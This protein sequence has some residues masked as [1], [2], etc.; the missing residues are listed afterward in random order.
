[1]LSMRHRYA[2]SS[3]NQDAYKVPNSFW[4]IGRLDMWASWLKHSSNKKDKCE[5]LVSLF[6]YSLLGWAF[7]LLLTALVLPC[8][9][10][11]SPHTCCVNEDIAKLRSKLRPPDPSV[12]FSVMPCSLWQK[13]AATKPILPTARQSIA[14]WPW[15]QQCT[16][17]ILMHTK[18][19]LQQHMWA[20]IEAIK[21]SKLNQPWGRGWPTFAAASKVAALPPNKPGGSYQR[22]QHSTFG[23]HQ[24]QV[25]EDV[26]RFQPLTLALGLLHLNCPGF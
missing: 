26:I 19:Y 20:Y 25:L 24:G 17:L 7:L 1:M 3:W 6:S 18:T 11:C 23:E 15:A 2:H 22:M 21:S 14:R 16:S 13:Q 12:P 9:S 8:L 10:S 4:I 5:W